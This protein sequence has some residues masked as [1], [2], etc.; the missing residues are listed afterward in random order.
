MTGRVKY[1]VSEVVF[2]L[3]VT[4]EVK[5]IFISGLKD[6][7]D[8]NLTVHGTNHNHAWRT[9]QALW[10]MPSDIKT[11]CKILENTWSIQTLNFIGLE[12]TSND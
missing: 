1:A 3:L 8:Y 9:A 4:K 7:H 5:P 10:L 6:V 11:A 12:I 2:V